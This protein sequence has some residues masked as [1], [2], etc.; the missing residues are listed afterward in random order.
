MILDTEEN[1]IIRVNNSKTNS[2]LQASALTLWRVHRGRLA[3]QSHSVRFGLPTGFRFFPSFPH[4]FVLKTLYGVY[5]VLISHEIC[6]SALWAVFTLWYLLC[7][8]TSV[9]IQLSGGGEVPQERIE[10][11]TSSR[12][13]R[14]S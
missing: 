11:K 10:R 7:R 4:P 12:T 1:R 8:Y 3:L 5:T 2:A 9:C 14:F 6:R 13:E